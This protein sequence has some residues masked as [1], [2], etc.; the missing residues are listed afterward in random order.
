MSAPT[1]DTGG[2]RVRVDDEQ[3]TITM[4]GGG[5]WMLPFGPR[6]LLD[7]ELE[8]ADPPQPYH[9]TNALGV[10]HDYFEDVIGAAPSVL[11]T[12]SVVATGR[13]VEALAVVEIGG[14]PVPEGYELS[15]A[16]AEEVFRTLVVEPVAERRFNPGLAEEHVETIVA[17]LCIVLPI[18]RR[19][20]LAA[21]G[22]TPSDPNAGDDR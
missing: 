7:R 2:L 1:P 4:T 13:H 10:V 15:R 16:D 22:V 3:V 18:M 14:G 6:T 8:R 9:L 19:L 12:P 21:I 5:D 20:N 11:A 17:T